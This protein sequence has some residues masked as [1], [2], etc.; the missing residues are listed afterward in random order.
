MRIILVI[1]IGLSLLTP[2][3]ADPCAAPD[4]AGGK[5]QEARAAD[6]DTPPPVAQAETCHCAYCHVPGLAA[7]SLGPN[8][9]VAEPA[10]AR[11]DAASQNGI[12]PRPLLEPP[13]RA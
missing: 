5:S 8:A 6:R 10:C 3:L 12:T 1:L 13:A 9:G 7:P 4:C 11:A 2:A